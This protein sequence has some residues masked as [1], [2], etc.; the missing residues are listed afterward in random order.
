MILR[1]LARWGLRLSLARA[2]GQ[3]SRAWL[4]VA[5]GALVIA[6]LARRREDRA[7]RAG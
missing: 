1:P 5:G 3:R 6:R 4:A 2:W 7:P